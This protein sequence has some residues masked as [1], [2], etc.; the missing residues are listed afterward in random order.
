MATNVNTRQTSVQRQQQENCDSRNNYTAG[1]LIKAALKKIIS[2]VFATFLMKTV[3][4][5]KGRRFT[6]VIH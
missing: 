5:P 2:R 6:N 4:H 1:D 3:L